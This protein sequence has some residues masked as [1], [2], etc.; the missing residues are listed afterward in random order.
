MKKETHGERRSCMT[1]PFSYAQDIV[2]ELLNNP[3][4][5]GLL[6]Q[7][8]KKIRRG[9]R[10]VLYKL[11]SE[12][13]DEDASSM[14]VACYKHVHQVGKKRHAIMR[15]D[16]PKWK[17]HLEVFWQALGDYLILALHSVDDIEYDDM[18]GVI[19]IKY[20]NTLSRRAKPPEFIATVIAKIAI[21]IDQEKL[22]IDYT[23]FRRMSER[24]G[25]LG[26]MPAWAGAL[27]AIAP[28]VI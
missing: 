23:R 26:E 16:I 18:R 12:V 1:C 21:L 19:M 28:K 13:S 7:I 6:E 15:F 27:M 20:S 11:I 3:G 10:E 8:A 2:E 5:G 22:Q 24:K 9:Q 17:G 14:P 25:T 4:Q